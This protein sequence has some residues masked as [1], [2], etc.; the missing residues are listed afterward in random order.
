MKTKFPVLPT[1]LVLVAMC[2]F[3]WKL[4]AGSNAMSQRLP[5]GVTNMPNGGVAIPWANLAALTA[6]PPG[7]TAGDVW[8][9]SDTGQTCYQNANGV[10][11]APL[12]FTTVADSTTLANPT[13]STTLSSTV[14]IPAGA[15]AAGR[16][17]EVTAYGKY[18]TAI[19]VTPT[20]QL[21]IAVDGVDVVTS[22]LVSTLT[23]LTDKAWTVTGTFIVRTAGAGG[24]M[25]AAM[26]GEL[27]GLLAA[28]LPVSQVGRSG[29]VAIN[30][31]T[32]HTIQPSALF[33]VTGAANAITCEG[34]L[35]TVR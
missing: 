22:G 12:S 31:T 3:A 33:G 28:A 24:T 29:S 27:G 1:W 21:G 14:T 5:S 13:V 11:A 2:V 17:V 7:A 19:T 15:L 34:L 30:T 23:T 32:A 4:N 35:V 6:T 18:T 8:Y 20:I 25:S 10:Q 16:V 26:R 9:R